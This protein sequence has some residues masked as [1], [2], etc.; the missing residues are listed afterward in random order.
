MQLTALIGFNFFLISAFICGEF[1]SDHLQQSD[2]VTASISL[3]AK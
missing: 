1:V 3:F 2:H